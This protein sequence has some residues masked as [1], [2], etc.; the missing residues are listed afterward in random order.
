MWSCDPSKAPG[1]DGY[2]LNFVRRMW[3]EIRK[4]IIDM[5]VK[6]F[7]LGTLPRNLKEQRYKGFSASQYGRISV[8]SY[9]KDSSKK[10]VKSDRGS[11]W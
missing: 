9:S 6:F 7:S 4:E 3:N 11:G 2:N 10:D 8:Q 1:S 5:V